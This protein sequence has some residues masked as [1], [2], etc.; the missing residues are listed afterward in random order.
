MYCWMGHWRPGL[1]ELDPT[2]P[3]AGSA[4][5]RAWTQLEPTGPFPPGPAAP[6]MARTE[7]QLEPTR[8]LLVGLP[9]LLEEIVTRILEETEDL[10]LVGVTRETRIAG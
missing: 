6:R 5:Y 3:R 10:T 7:W 2:R 9:R 4:R 1:K 8:I